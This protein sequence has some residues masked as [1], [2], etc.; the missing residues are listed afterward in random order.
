M[1]DWVGYTSVENSDQPQSQ[2]QTDNCCFVDRQCSTDEEWTSGYW[3]FQNNQCSAP[4]QS[5]QQTS[6]QPAISSPAQ[7]DNCCF[8]NRQCNTDAEWTYGYF[9]FQNNHCQA[10]SQSAAVNPR[11]QAL[12][13]TAATNA[14]SALEFNNC[15]FFPDMG[16][17]SSADW[18]NGYLAFRNHQCVHPAPIA[19]R[20]KI[21]GPAHFV[22]W[23][24][25]ALELLGIQGPEWLSYVY[26]SGLRTIRMIPQGRGSRFS[27]QEWVF[28]FSYD[29]SNNPDNNPEWVPSYDEILGMVGVIAHESCHSFQ[30]RTVTYSSIG[31]QNELPCLEA[32][33]A[34]MIAIDPGHRWVDAIQWHIDNIHDPTTW[35]W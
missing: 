32:Q 12:P 11:T 29:S 28:E 23:I 15:C 5:Q 14:L 16:C 1:A 24:E 21:E 33:V 35:W 19:T 7:I 9:A 31:W 4:S 27:N 6:S 26:S 2:S 20:P 34:S 30:Q 8:V 25:K 3:A 18:S 13:Q 22:N 10:P 17:Q